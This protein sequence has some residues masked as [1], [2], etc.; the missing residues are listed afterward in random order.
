MFGDFA[1][2]PPEINSGLIYTGPGSGSLWAAAQIW[3]QLAAD[4]QRT[5]E[6][7]RS[8]IADL[9]SFEWL[10]PSSMSMVAAVIPYVEWLQ[11]T[12]AQAQ[13]T[14][15]Q[16]AEAARAYEQAFEMTVP[17][18]VIATNRAELLWL[19][20]TNFFGENSTAMAALEFAYAEMWVTDSIAMQDYA[21]TSVAATALPPFTPPQQMADPAGLPA[22][23][24]AIAHAT[25]GAA[26]DDGNWI[27]NLLIEI[28]TL[29]IPIAPELTPIFVSAGEFVNEL[30]LPSIVSDDFTFLD[31][32]MAFYA[33]ISSIN[34]INSMGTGIIG[35]ENDLGLIPAMAAP[36]VGAAPVELA[37]L[38]NSVRTVADAVATGGLGRSLGEVSAAVRGAGSI[39]QMS[40]PP[41][42]T[43]PA[44]PT[45]RPL[46]GTPMT[47]LPAG[48]AIAP[49]MP[50]IPGM[51]HARADRG[52][53][54]PRYGVTPKVMSRPLAGG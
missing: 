39:G 21:G 22:Q 49:G 53:V 41:A 28:G 2:Y 9:V 34:N 12:A 45:V 13:Q 6:A 31:G 7:Y 51:A 14:A 19:N 30:P 1:M 35:A 16:A 46:L 26:A 52:G 38:V 37:P 25:A 23:T 54:V 43:A 15:A 32:V 47:T 48:D 10:G 42:W 8:L 18:Q 36:V 11:T 33:T 27:G 29:L 40:V 24:A 5:A 17:P 4:L 20:A 50:G 44:V 3:E